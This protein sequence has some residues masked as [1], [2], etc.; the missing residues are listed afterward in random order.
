MRPLLALGPT[1]RGADRSPYRTLACEDRAQEARGGYG[2]S[3]AAVAPFRGL[4]PTARRYPQT[5]EDAEDAYQRGVEILLTKAPTTSEDDLLPWLKTVVKHEAFAV[6][7]ASGRA[8]PHEEPL[9]REPDERAWTDD[10]AERYERLRLA[11]EAMA[12]LKPQEIRC[13]LLKAE[14]LS[15]QEICSATAFSY[16][17]VNRCLTEGRRAFL[18]RVAGI[19][20]GA[21][22]A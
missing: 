1:R 9:A 15:Y 22:C 6:A 13:L 10:R 20:A 7:R 3:R 17:K 12:G 16:T 18:K 21:E 8:V 4:L 2:S 5:P 11:A 14:G 19:E